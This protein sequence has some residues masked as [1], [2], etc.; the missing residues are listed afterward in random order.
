MWKSL[1][2]VLCNRYTPVFVV[3]VFSPTWCVC[4]SLFLFLPR[5][6]TCT[7]RWFAQ[8]A[9]FFYF[10]VVVMLYL[11]NPKNA[12]NL[13]QARNRFVFFSLRI[14]SSSEISGPKTEM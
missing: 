7:Y 3:V 5:E 13:N 1:D 6:N 8:H 9:A 11:A 2:Q 10:F 12:Y 4:R 14:S